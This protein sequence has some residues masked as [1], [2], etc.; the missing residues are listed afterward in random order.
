V[1]LLHYIIEILALTQ[2]TTP[3]QR[4]LGLEFFNGSG[5]R[6]ILVYVDH[7][8]LQIGRI[9]QGFTEESLG[10]RCIAFWR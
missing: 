4:A 8:G 5:I 9:Q 10:C 6:S 2:S 3:T 1:V 7:P